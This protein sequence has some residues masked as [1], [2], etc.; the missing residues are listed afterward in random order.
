MQQQVQMERV[1][2]TG[3]VYSGEEARDLVKLNEQRFDFISQE[4]KID[5]DRGGVKRW[6]VVG[7]RKRKEQNEQRDREPS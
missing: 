4:S 5:P 1:F 6:R 2:E 7:Y 3:Y